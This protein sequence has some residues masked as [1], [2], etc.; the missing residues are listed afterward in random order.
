M[1]GKPMN[2]ISPDLSHQVRAQVNFLDRCGPKPAVYQYA[3]P[4]GVQPIDARRDPREITI[5]SARP[6][7]GGLTLDAQGFAVIKAPIAIADWDNANA[8]RTLYDDA[9]ADAVLKATGARKA[10]V[11]DHTVRRFGA[12]NGSAQ[13]RSPVFVAHN[14]YTKKSGPQRVRDLLPEADA[15]EA[16]KGRYAIINLWRSINGIVEDTPL[17][18]AD[19]R[20]VKDDDF[21]ATDL[22]YPDRTGE[23]YR[24]GYNPEH[25]WFYVPKLRPDEAILIKSFDSADDG[26][27]RFTPHTAFAHPGTTPGT[28]KRA[29]I[30]SRVLVFY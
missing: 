6:L 19:A 13:T 22:I 12:S 26:R 27:A 14:D 1:L 7:Q 10:L 20:T 15:N 28:E 25:R 24:I 5:H 16:L 8:L 30:E 18:F 2:S 17:T 4:D 29:S 3:P 23:V 11:F 9:V 21:I